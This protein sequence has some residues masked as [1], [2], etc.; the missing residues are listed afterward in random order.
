MHD[1][2]IEKLFGQPALEELS[3]AERQLP[4]G[5]GKFGLVG[6]SNVIAHCVT[7]GGHF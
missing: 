1:S 7:M 6:V 2:L 3:G 5:L 4:D